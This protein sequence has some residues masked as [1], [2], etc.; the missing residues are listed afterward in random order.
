MKKQDKLSLS[1]EHLKQISKT[2]NLIE[3]TLR[4]IN[5]S[6]SAVK[7]TDELLNIAHIYTVAVRG[8]IVEK[9]DELSVSNI[10]PHFIKISRETIHLLN[11]IKDMKKR[12]NHQ[13]TDGIHLAWANTIESVQQLQTAISDIDA[14]LPEVIA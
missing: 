1:D 12:L 8:Y 14:I 4:K 10:E 13:G 3:K 7:S 9:P 6:P 2:I 5:F 11:H